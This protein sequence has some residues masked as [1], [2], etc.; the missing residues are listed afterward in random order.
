MTWKPQILIRNGKPEYAVLP[1]D[2]Y[3]EMQACLED[4]ADL[5]ALDRARRQD[6]GK[7]TIGIDEMMRRL[8]MR[9]TKKK[10]KGKSPRTLARKRRR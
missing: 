2:Q 5:I 1:Y 6:A 8:G 10:S 9:S 4:A 7:P 3:E